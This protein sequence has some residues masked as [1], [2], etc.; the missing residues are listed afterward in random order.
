MEQ[1]RKILIMS[2]SHGTAVYAIQAIEREKPIDLLIHLGDL[3]GSDRE[4]S[5]AAG[6]PCLFV[7]GNC[8]YDHMIPL[9]REIPIGKHK[10]FAAHGHMQHVRD[11][12]E[13]LERTAKSYG[14]DIAMYGHTHVPDLREKEDITVLN[15]GS[16]S[17]PRQTKPKKT[18]VVMTHDPET[19]KLDYE[20][21]N[22]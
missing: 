22:L 4:I 20:L 1:P 17:R 11:G 16:I 10:I 18:Y 8:D 9:S 19:G 6:C 2:D 7:R 15:P 5:A 13:Y 21:K 14:C 3:Q 12:T